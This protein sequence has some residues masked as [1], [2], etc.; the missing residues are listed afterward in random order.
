[1]NEEHFAQ[2]YED[3]L[4]RLEVSFYESL[5]PEDQPLDDDGPDYIDSHIDEFDVFCR[6]KYEE[7]HEN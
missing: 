4:E 1:M 2:W 7:E 3:N 6:D 5:P